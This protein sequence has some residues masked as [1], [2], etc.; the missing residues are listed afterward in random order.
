M[1][2]FHSLKKG[3][4]GAVSC[5]RLSVIMTRKCHYGAIKSVQCVHSRESADFLYLPA[6]SDHRTNFIVYMF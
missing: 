6:Y 4:E 5:P 1:G 3:G 2:I